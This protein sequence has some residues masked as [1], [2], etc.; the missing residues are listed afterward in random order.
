MKNELN[1]KPSTLA[2]KLRRLRKAVHS[3]AHENFT[4]AKIHQTSL[5]YKTMLG[6][7]RLASQ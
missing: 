6:L 3:M 4:D 2:E 5:Q 7:I 1:Y